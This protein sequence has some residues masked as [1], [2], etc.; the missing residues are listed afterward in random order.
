MTQAQ[1]YNRTKNFTDNSGDR[2]DHA[3]LNAEL[4]AVSVSV[5]ELR[6][7]QATLQNDDGTLAFKSV[8]FDQLTDAAKQGLQTPGPKGDLGPKGDQGPIGPAGPKGSVGASFTTDNK[9]L[10]A[11]RTNYDG[12]PA[13]TSYLAMD[14]GMLYFK[15]SGTVADWSTGYTFGKGDKGDQGPKGD[16]GNQGTQGFRGVTGNQGVKGDAGPAGPAGTVDYTKVIRLDNA[17][18]QTM[19]GALAAQSFSTSQ[20]MSAQTFVFAT[21]DTRMQISAGRIQVTDTQ[22]TPAL[23]GM[24]V[25]DVLTAGTGALDTGLKIA[26]GADIGTLF[27]PAGAADSKLSGADV[28]PVVVDISGKTSLTLALQVVGNQVKIV[29][30]AT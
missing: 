20:S 16:Q 8:G 19:Q 22:S 9:G 14:N 29:A 24:Q 3:A 27:D 23:K 11:Q 10:Y 12:A 21:Q 1:A 4:D 5:N 6:E 7:N 18:T 28:T 2:T 15:L 25:K 30:S 17:G 13:G 26:T